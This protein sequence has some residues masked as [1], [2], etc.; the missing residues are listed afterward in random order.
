MTYKSKNPAVIVAI[1]TALGIICVAI[2]QYHPWTE[3]TNK[4]DKNFL[5]IHI[6]SGTIID[7]K[8]NLNISQAEINVVGR[9]EQYFSEENGNFKIQIKD[10][11][12]SIRLRVLK[13]GFR[14]FDK[15]YDLS[16]EGVIIQLS[17]ITHE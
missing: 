3:K 6:L 11:I 15:S 9:N 5:P 16:N 8:T 14:P 7:E 1:I 2:I 10:S 4:I 17:K 13:K 12:K